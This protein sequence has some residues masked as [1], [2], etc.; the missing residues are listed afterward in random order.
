MNEKALQYP[1]F[2]AQKGPSCSMALPA[3]SFLLLNSN[4]SVGVQLAF[5]WSPQALLSLL[6][7]EEVLGTLANGLPT[8]TVAQFRKE[9][10]ETSG[11]EHPVPKGAPTLAQLLWIQTN[12]NT[13]NPAFLRT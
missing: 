4:P 3:V 1:T 8:P 10:W 9:P 5:L 2:R 11:Q 7:T 12:S 6:P 13:V